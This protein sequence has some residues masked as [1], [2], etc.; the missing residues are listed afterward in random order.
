ML[1]DIDILLDDAIA[2]HKARDFSL[3]MLKYN[4]ILEKDA[5]HADASYNFGLLT[6]EIGLEN[7]ALNFFQSAIK[8]NPNQVQ[9]W[10]ALIRTLIRIGKFDEAEIALERAQLAG[11]SAEE[12]SHLINEFELKQNE[13]KIN[14]QVGFNKE[15]MR[16]EKDGHFAPLK[17]KVSSSI[18]SNQ[19]GESINK[20]SSNILDKL[21]LDQA[22]KL[23]KKNVKEGN[24]E[25]AKIIYR[26]ILERFP[27]NRKALTGIKAIPSGR[28]I[29]GSNIQN[30]PAYQIQNLFS[31]LNAGHLEKTLKQALKSLME[32]PNSAILYNLVGISNQGL[33]RLDEAIQAFNAA[34]SLDP[35]NADAFY[36][37][38][39]VLQDQGKLEEAI[40]SYQK[41]V[42][43]EPNYAE[44]YN[45]MG[46]ALNDQGKLDAAKSAYA[47][48]YK[49]KPD[50][51]DAY[52]NMGLL[53]KDQSKLEEAK[54]AFKE[55]LKIEPWNADVSYNMG[56]VLQEQ[57]K[58][59]EAIAA[60]DK[61]VLVKPDYADAF[62]NMAIALQKQ[63]KLE[64][65]IEAYQ[66]ALSIKPAYAEAFFRMGN[67][68]QDQGKLEE[69]MTAYTKSVSIK[70][71]YVQAW[72][73][74]ANA[75]ERW[76]KIEQL[77][78][79][80]KKAVKNLKTTPS[81]I[82]FFQAKLLWRNKKIK[83]AS[84][85]ISSIEIE[86]ISDV[87]KQHYLDLKAKCFDKLKIFE[88]AF[89]CYS[90]MNA[91]TKKSSDYLNSDPE[92][93]FKD[94][95]NK[96]TRIRNSKVLVSEVTNRNIIGPNPIFLVG[97]PRSGTTLLDTILRSHSKVEVV[98]EKPILKLAKA[99]IEKNGYTDPIN[100]TIPIELI[101]QAQKLYKNEL[102]K[103]I[104]EL[105]PNSIFIDKLPLNIL[106]APFIHK[107]YPKAKFIL[108]LRHPL[109]T[110]LSCWMQNFKL[111]PAMANM[112]DLDRIVEFYCIS[113]EAFQ[114][115]RTQY[116]LAVH[117]IKY[118]NLVED[119]MEETA[120]LLKFL[121]LNWET[122]IKNYKDTA[123]KRGLINTPSYSQVVQ[124]IYKD[125][126]YRWA[127]Y[128]KYLEQYLDQVEPWVSKFG[129]N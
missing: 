4:E 107:L 81:D 122:E 69:A 9:Y 34:L 89:E 21:K 123:L 71:D 64:N 79:W 111:N 49:I 45:N 74:G 109:D 129:Y 38:G 121:N 7:E 125:A 98:E 12:I 100:Q 128:R 110:I 54:E 114:I 40:D 35:T 24:N 65:S 32:F 126:S 56:I 30:P 46:I 51:V 28:C 99:F 76:N 58:L 117:E 42:L 43:I 1:D 47:K 37:I 8:A 19:S 18:K 102:K 96:L 104:P 112:V 78:V 6:R 68:L 29:N 44:A 2:A 85:L 83:E 70:P 31:L 115:C 16:A 63:G 20:S 80:L 60:Y 66:K 14:L 92:K 15:G 27:K 95:R 11:Y 13:K 62:Y 26:N 87:R 118:E 17:Q 3:A 90:E 61:T 93:Y 41:G 116:D 5:N 91:I 113:M 50:Y 88:G 53:L 97:F 127:N 55:A 94:V 84:A 73:N 75:L 48:A 124:P 106:E 119:F 23:A 59:E 103:L 86:Q 36:N 67:A 101:T 105:N 25:Q 120:A 108:A 22:L 77:E 72:S 57:G 10:E 82:K 39:S 52:N 33:G